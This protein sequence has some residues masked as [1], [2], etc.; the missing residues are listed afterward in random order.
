VGFLKRRHVL[1]M[2]WRVEYVCICIKIYIVST[3]TQ[4]CICVYALAVG[5]L[6]AK[7]QQCWFP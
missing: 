3:Y 2:I 4:I 5:F 1:E 7:P 6:N